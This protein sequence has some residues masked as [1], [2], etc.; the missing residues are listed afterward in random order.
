MS[1]DRLIIE[2]AIISDPEGLLVF[3]IENIITDIEIFEHIDK[4]YLTGLV[5]FLDTAG[6]YDK[7]RFKGAESFH[8]ALKYPEDDGPTVNRSFIINGIVDTAKNNDKS[9]IITFKIIEER[10]FKCE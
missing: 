8:L 5:S 7:M 1:E 9:E 10:G 3:E 4:P 2:K 6:I